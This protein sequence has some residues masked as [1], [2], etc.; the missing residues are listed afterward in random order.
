VKDWFKNLF[1]YNFSEHTE[2]SAKYL[3]DKST[4]CEYNIADIVILLSNKID[5][6]EEKYKCIL[7]DFK[8]LE[9][10]NI[11]LTNALY[12][13]ENRLDSKI[14]NIHPVVY[15]FQDN[16]KLDNYTLGDK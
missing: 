11:E 8:H 7:L 12:E 6:L 16:A 2:E 9:E 4:G 15:N 10:E 1:D 5:D 14:D 13:L 3:I